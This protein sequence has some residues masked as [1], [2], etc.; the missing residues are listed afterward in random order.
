MMKIAVLFF[1]LF[2][3][4]ASAGN[5]EEMVSKLYETDS[6]SLQAAV[7]SQQAAAG[8]SEEY[9]TT[10]GKM[11][12]EANQLLRVHRSEWIEHCGEV[13]YGIAKTNANSETCISILKNIILSQSANIKNFEAVISNIKTQG[14]PTMQ[15][16]IDQRNDIVRLNG[17]SAVH[18]QIRDVAKNWVARIRK[19]QDGTKTEDDLYK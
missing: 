18:E 5:F 9:M 17:E 3:F 16:N 2:V 6:K 10:V 14:V 11:T 4:E 15:A 8:V 7:E 12:E 1:S 19:V 13:A